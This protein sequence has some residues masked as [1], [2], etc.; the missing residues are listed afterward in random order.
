MARFWSTILILLV[1]FAVYLQVT[2]PVADYGGREPL[3]SISH[4]AI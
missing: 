4:F 2:V 3:T 1:A